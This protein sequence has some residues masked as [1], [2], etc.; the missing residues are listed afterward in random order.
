M[1]EDIIPHQIDSRPKNLDDLLD[2]LTIFGDQV[3]FRITKHSPDKLYFSEKL[4]TQKQ[5][6]DYQEA[7]NRFQEAIKRLEDSQL[8]KTQR[9]KT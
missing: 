4:L 2:D 3:N 1:D 8:G 5:F 9:P 6:N 7:I